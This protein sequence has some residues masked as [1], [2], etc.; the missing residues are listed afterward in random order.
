[1]RAFVALP[2]EAA[3]DVTA[4]LAEALLAAGHELLW[5]ASRPAPIAQAERQAFTLTLDRMHEADLLVADVSVPDTSVGWAVAWFVARG[6][7]VVLCCQRGGRDVLPVLIAGN[8][9][10]WV[11]LIMY[12][13]GAQ[14][15]KAIASIVG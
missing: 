10:P 5:P 8:P 7:L 12:D 3:D 6:R 1:M 9:S 13:D 2:P 11:R 15:S 4:A 14:L